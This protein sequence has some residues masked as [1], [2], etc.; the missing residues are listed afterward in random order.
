MET[1][2]YELL[3]IDSGDLILDIGCGGGRHAF[4]ALRR[5]AAVIACDAERSELPAVSGMMETMQ[6]VGE[7]RGRVL[8]AAVC[9]NA[10]KLPFADASFKYVIASE[11]LEHIGADTDA[12]GEMVR[13]LATGGVLAVSAPSWLSEKICWKLSSDYHAPARPGGHVRIYTRAALR[14]LLSDGGLT[15]TRTHRAH[16][17]HSPYWWLR[18][19]VGPD[20]DDNLLV[21]CYHRFLCWDMIRRPLLGRL[22]ERLL[23][24]FIGKSLVL[25]AVKDPTSGALDPRRKPPGGGSAAEGKEESPQATRSLRVPA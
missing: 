17:L 9:G 7:A 11:V 14:K 6:S 2:R 22:L 10:L 13:V 24:P 21:R 20:N 8:A 5:G 16:A 23:N 15:P 18:C 25:Y 1:I 4:G 12:V 3:G 19:A